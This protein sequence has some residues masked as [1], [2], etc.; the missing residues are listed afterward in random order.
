MVETTVK[1]I[2]AIFGRKPMQ[3]Q[4]DEYLNLLADYEDKI[5]DDVFINIRDNHSK[6]PSL[7]ELKKIVRAARETYRPA[8]NSLASDCEWCDGVGLIPQ[9]MSP[10]KY[11][12]INRYMVANY[13]CQCAEG[14]SLSNSIPMINDYQFTDERNNG[15]NYGTLIYKKQQEFNKRLL[16]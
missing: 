15:L 11:P 16:G 6:L 14:K 3:A 7:A 2:F 10:R 1:R 4:I 13:R 8:A 5:V 9:L 12:N